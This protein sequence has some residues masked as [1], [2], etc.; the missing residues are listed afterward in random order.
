MTRLLILLA[1]LASPGPAPRAQ[2]VPRPP[3]AQVRIDFVAEGRGGA[4]VLDLKPA[5]LEVWIGH[6]RV[7]IETFTLVTAQ[8]DER[9]GRLIVLLLDDVTLPPEMAPRARE[10]ARRFVTRM[11]P[12]DRMAIVTLSGATSA[13]STDSSARLLRTLDSYNVR[14]SGVMRTDVLS[15]QVLDT[16]ATLSRQ[17]AEA[18]GRRKTIV[19]I[20]PSA[21][22]DRPLPP[23]GVGRDLVPQWVGAMRA[24]A[25][26]H[27]NFYVI[28]PGGVGAT[29]VGTGEDGFARAS[30][31]RA[32]LSTNDVNGAVDR[33][34]RDASAY[35]VVSVPSPPTGGRDTL[36]ELE[37]RVLRRG[38]RVLAPRAIP[39]GS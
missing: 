5:D 6:F 17:M 29:R 20:G 12:G 8:A 23:P 11:L 35:Y 4:P 28:D 15:E 39:G 1:L 2:D 7:P 26:A 31:G 14:A 13:E 25:F 38:V 18:P 22:F 9:E 30:G 10:A 3:A 34:L 16:V 21:V 27:A 24:M 36:R 37:I 33:I 32:F 19:A